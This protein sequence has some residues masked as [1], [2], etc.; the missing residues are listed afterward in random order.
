M[1]TNSVEHNFYVNLRNGTNKILRVYLLIPFLHVSI[2]S[3]HL[4]GDYTITATIN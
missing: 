1:Q 3:D 4:Q 2:S